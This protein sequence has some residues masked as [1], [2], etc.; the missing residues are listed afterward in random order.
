MAGSVNK[1]TLVGN[2]VSD[3]NVSNLNSGD[4]VVSLRV[5]TSETWK[6]KAS[7]ERKE[8]SEF[9]NVVVFNQGLAVVVRDYVK[10][11]SKLY[12]EGQLQTRKYQDKD[13]QERYTTEIVLQKYK[14]E[15]VL[16]DKGGHR[17]D[18]GNYSNR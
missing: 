6:D 9:H 1:V 7:G 18:N 4:I 3:P 10:K 2:V 5:A 11:G 14:G 16:L 13:G 12:L 15:V 8:R 17:D